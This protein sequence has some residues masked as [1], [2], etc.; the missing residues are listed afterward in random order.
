M[1]S[2][3]LA[4]CTV[5]LICL[6]GR[7]QEEY[8]RCRPRSPGH[9]GDGREDV[10]QPGPERARGG[11][12]VVVEGKMEEEEESRCTHVKVLRWENKTRTSL[13][14]TQS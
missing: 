10:T 11:R 5:P 8:F 9:D 7:E 1:V 2:E 12:A 3:W 4:P 14:E 13:R 6:T